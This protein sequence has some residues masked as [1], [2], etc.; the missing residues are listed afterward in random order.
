MSPLYR[1]VK[2]LAIYTV[3]P[4]VLFLVWEICARV[5][6]LDQ[7]FFPAPSA[8]FYHLIFVSPEEGI[9]TD[10]IYSVYRIFVG[11]FI[12]C[13]LGLLLGVGMGL[14]HALRMAFYPL[15]IVTYPI[16]KIAILPLIML[17]FGIGDLSKIVV[18]AIGSFFLV[19]M[20]TLHGVDSL[21][22]I[23][24]DVA[25]VY[26]I[27]RR[28][29]IVKIVIPGS[30]PSIFTG[31]KLAIGYSLVIVVAA[32][33]SGAD[34][35]IGY[36]IWQSWETFSIKSM[37]AGIFVIGVLGFIFSYTLDF[38]ERRLVPWIDKK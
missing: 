13:G 29:F 15:I 8:I 7:R 31:L 16:P 32:E 11:Y 28:S 26:K 37:Y 17:I 22:K 36:L 25:R 9:V 3:S 10:V 18:V 35:G 5:G 27:R 20:N 34:K 33:F 12:G 2:R 30:L 6:W 14:S 1:D 4:L 21:A 23:Y 38:L 24:H 19:L